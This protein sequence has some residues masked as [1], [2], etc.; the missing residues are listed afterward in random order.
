MMLRSFRDNIKGRTGKVILALII[1]PFVGFGAFDLL[2]GGGG[3]AEILEVNGLTADEVALAQELQ[4]TRN[5]LI[6]RMGEDVNYEELTVEKL[7]PIA[8]EA[9][10]QRL[11]LEDTGQSLNMGIPDAL[12]DQSIISDEAFQVDGKFSSEQMTQLLAANGFDLSMLK[13]KTR[14]GMLDRQFQAGIARSSFSVEPDVSLLQAINGEKRTVDLLQLN[15][16]D[17]ESRIEVSPEEVQA[18]YDNHSEMFVT[19]FAVDAEYVSLS[20]DDFRPEISEAQIAEEYARQSDLFD[21][22]E[23]RQVSHILFEVTSAQS[24]EA[25]IVKATQAKSR[26]ENGETFADLARE[27]SEDSGSAEDGGDLGFSERDGSFPPAFENVMFEIGTGEVSEPVLTDSGVHLIRVGQIESSTMQSLPELRARIIDQLQLSA[28][29]R[30]FVE[31][32]ESLADMVF[33]ADDLTD[34]AKSLG[35]ELRSISRLT[36]SG[37]SLDGQ[38]VDALFNNRVLNVLYSD[39][40]LQE[41]L[42]SEMIEL[43]EDQRLVVRVAKSH[44]PRALTLEEAKP[45]I[46]KILLSEK[47]SSEL[48]AVAN[49]ITAAVESGEGFAKAAADH[50]TKLA[51][52]LVLQRNSQDMDPAVMASIFMLPRSSAGEPVHRATDRNGNVTLFQL[53]SVADD[54]DSSS[55]SIA[56]LIQQ[57]LEVLYARQEYAAF[58]GSVRQRAE[59]TEY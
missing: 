58:W 46:R 16:A 40:V 20:V 22:V 18:Y 2:T 27:L 33:N 49:A 35:L 41:G 34:S 44:P 38:E 36:R 19:E 1:I 47:L 56:G 8:R 26:I 39:E 37:E 14:S 51:S 54:E 32:S 3:A 57:Q 10:L 15:R 29:T 52:D 55:E 11:L 24:E 5:S 25:A 50:S 30:R 48:E 4:L 43:S 31:V 28:A 53:K 9:I 12:V 23:S 42:N 7:S 59:I 17:Y 21:P 45:R 6:S 13:Q